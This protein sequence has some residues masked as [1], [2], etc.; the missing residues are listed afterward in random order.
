MFDQCLSQASARGSN[1]PRW[2]SRRHGI[3]AMVGLAA[4]LSTVT[5]GAAVAED[6]D[7][8]VLTTTV[9]VTKTMTPVPIFT[10]TLTPIVIKTLTPVPAPTYT[11]TPTTPQTLTPVVFDPT[12]SPT[13]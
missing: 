11:L 4:L 8:I 7:P 3:A 2:G 1:R 13:P 6:G 10:K 12:P 5:G 9:V